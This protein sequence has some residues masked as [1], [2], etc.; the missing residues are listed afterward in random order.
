MK[1][2]ITKIAKADNALYD[3]PPIH[4]Y[5]MGEDNG[6]V[7]LPIE[8]W[9]EGFINEKPT[10]GEGLVVSRTSRNGVEVS[11]I[12]TTSEITEITDKGFKTLN[13]VYKL[14]YI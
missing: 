1:V 7:S 13:S 6:A 3:A 14:E 10:V 11:G 12:F 5:V 8:Y 4:D 2:R 9:L